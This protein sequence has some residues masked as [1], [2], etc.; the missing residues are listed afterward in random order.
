MN[1]DKSY[2]PKSVFKKISNKKM[3]FPLKYE[4]LLNFYVKTANETTYFWRP[5]TDSVST[6]DADRW[7]TF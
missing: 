6:G 4:K 2:V 7:K 3:C 1:L 5:K